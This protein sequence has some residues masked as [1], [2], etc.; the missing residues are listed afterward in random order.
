MQS[1]PG[2]GSLVSRCLYGFALCGHFTFSHFHGIVQATGFFCFAE[3]FR[4]PTRVICIPTLFLLRPNTNPSWGEA[5]CYLSGHQEM[6]VQVAST[7][8]L[9][10]LSCRGH[11]RTTFCGNGCLR[12]SWAYTS[13]WDCWIGGWLRVGLS[14]DL[15]TPY[16]FPQRQ[17]AFPPPQG[18][19]RD[20]P[21]P[22]P[23]QRGR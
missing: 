18:S 20:P 11:E 7:F 1:L 10:G 15:R 16:L 22:R 14:E 9:V 21:S 3:H 6:G 4:A 8:G 23:H 19:A 2:P 13:M 17:P 12:V 5:T